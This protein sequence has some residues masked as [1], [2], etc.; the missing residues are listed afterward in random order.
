MERFEYKEAI[1][2][3]LQKNKIDHYE[4]RGNTYISFTCNE[5]KELQKINLYLQKLLNITG[6]NNSIEYLENK[7]YTL[8]L[9]EDYHEEYPD[10]E[11][12]H[13]WIII[14][15]DKV[16]DKISNLNN[17]LEKVEVYRIESENKG[18]YASGKINPQLFCTTNNPEPESDP[19]LN[20][21]FSTDLYHNS[22]YRKEWYFCFEDKESAKKWINSKEN[23][24][25]L[26]LSGFDLVSYRINKNL[27][28]K[29]NGQ[30]VFKKEFAEEINKEPLHLLFKHNSKLSYTL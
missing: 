6:K 17:S 24:E 1:Y 12:L 26:T 2:N 19:K 8:Q 28:I 3:L 20:F 14:N 22:E 16:Y 10:D 18:L 23:S 9:D 29:G 21:I 27:L 4:S 7:L 30:C 15:I 5:E 11:L 25:L 13:F